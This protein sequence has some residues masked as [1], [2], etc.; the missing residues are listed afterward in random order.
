MTHP[1]TDPGL[2]P[3]DLLARQ[4]DAVE[5]LTLTVELLQGQVENLRRRIQALEG[6]PLPDQEPPEPG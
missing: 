1:A 3:L 6:V 5:Q 4:Q 2:T